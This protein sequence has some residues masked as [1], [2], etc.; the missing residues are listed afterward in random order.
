MYIATPSK[1]MYH[2]SEGCTTYIMGISWRQIEIKL[3]R[4][5]VYI[6]FFIFH[7]MFEVRFRA[8]NKSEVRTATIQG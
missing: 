6:H 7:S 8:L 4:L 5:D 3:K 2:I 1:F